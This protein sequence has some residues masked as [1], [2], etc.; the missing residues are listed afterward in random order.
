[1]NKRALKILLVDDDRDLLDLFELLLEMDNASVSCATNYHNA[2]RAF[3][4]EHFDIVITDWSMP[5]MTGLYLLDMVKSAKPE[6]PV[7]IITAYL[8]DKIKNEA[9]LKKADLILE[10]PFDYKELHAGILRL[11]KK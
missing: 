9:K 4:K 1:M 5:I 7:I 11:A 2:L 8:T 10:K 6:I 3:E